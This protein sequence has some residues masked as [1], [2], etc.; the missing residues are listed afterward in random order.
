[1]TAS[2][3]GPAGQHDDRHDLRQTALYIVVTSKRLFLGTVSVH[4]GSYIILYCFCQQARVAEHLHV[5]VLHNSV[6]LWYYKHC[7]PYDYEQRI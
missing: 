4:S 5:D 7:H 3:G 1:M 2:A 6:F